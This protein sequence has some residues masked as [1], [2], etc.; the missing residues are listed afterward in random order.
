MRKTLLVAAAVLAILSFAGCENDSEN[1]PNSPEASQSINIENTQPLPEAEVFP[2]QPSQMEIIFGEARISA[3][4]GSYS[5]RVDGKDGKSQYTIADGIH[6]LAAKE[7]MPCLSLKPKVSSM[8]T[9]TAQLVFDAPPA[10]VTAE[11]WPLE[12]FEDQSMRSEMASVDIIEIDYADGRNTCDYTL[13]LKNDNYIYH[14][15]AEWEKAGQYGGSAEYCFYTEYTI[16]EA[17]SIET[18]NGEILIFGYPLR[19]NME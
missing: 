17:E 16:P 18:E 6:P 1:V 14:I 2:A 5:W 7:H 11:C 4:R 10:K 9:Y 12:A 13:H 19:E 3:M 8:N 15:T